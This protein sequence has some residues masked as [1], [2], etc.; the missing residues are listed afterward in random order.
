VFDKAIVGNLPLT[1]FAER[2]EFVIVVF[3]NMDI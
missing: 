3:S 1:L 2:R